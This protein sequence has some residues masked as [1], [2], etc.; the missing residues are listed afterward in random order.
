MKNSTL[1]PEES[2]L[3]ITKT[4]E[5]TK[6]RFKENGH[7]LIF[8]G[9][10]TVI[11]FGGQ[12]LLWYLGLNEYMIHTTYLFFIG[13]I[14]T[15]IYMWREKKKRNIP[16]TIISNVLNMG[17]IIGLNLMVMGFF[18]SDKLGE[19]LG[20]VFIILFALML[21]VI[22]LTIRFKPLIIGGILTNTIG[23][24][25]FWLNDD[26]HGLSLIIAAIVG[27]IIPGVLLNKTRSK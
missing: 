23:L 14:Y 8:W 20:P 10:L 5:D 19:A 2:L 22:G 27:M 7:I 16:K 18:F 15:G 25:T 24:C 26:Y 4:I 11:V 3:L 21:T 6:E 13:A 17:W 12:Y 1:T 9:I